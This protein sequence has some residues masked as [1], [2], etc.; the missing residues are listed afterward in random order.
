MAFA[1]VLGELDRK[2]KE[3]ETII[4]RIEGVGHH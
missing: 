2:T 4:K 1:N 3:V